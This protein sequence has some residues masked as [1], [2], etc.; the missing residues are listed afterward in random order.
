MLATKAW[1]YTHFPLGKTSTL[2]NTYF[3]LARRVRRISEL[4]CYVGGS[5]AADRTNHTGQVLSKSTGKERYPC[6]SGVEWGTDN[7][8]NPP[9]PPPPKRNPHWES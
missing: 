7:L 2:S 4:T 6:P 3:C 1:Q 9:P 8:M 5:P